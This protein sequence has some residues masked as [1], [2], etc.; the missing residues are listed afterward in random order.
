MNYLRVTDFKNK[1]SE[2]YC[3]AYLI[4]ST[5]KERDFSEDYILPDFLPDAKKILKFTAKPVIETRFIGNSNL[6]YSGSI[7]CRALY[8]AENST[9]CCA[10][11][12]VPFEDKLSDESLTDECVDF[13]YPRIISPLCRLQNP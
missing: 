1:D 5:K 12:T 6:E 8:L 11:F 10:S 13:L 9:L 7:Y 3:G 4:E 2:D